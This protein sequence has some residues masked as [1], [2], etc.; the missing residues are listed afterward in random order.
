MKQNSLIF[1]LLNFY[2]AAALLL[3]ASCSD[4]DSITGMGELTPDEEVFGKAN[5][6]FTAEEC[7]VTT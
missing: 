2:I 6:V 7:S 5:D 4:D 3:L 1:R